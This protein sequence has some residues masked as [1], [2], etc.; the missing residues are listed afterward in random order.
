MQA[1][2]GLSPGGLN[3]FLIHARMALPK[4]FFDFDPVFL[5]V[6]IIHILSLGFLNYS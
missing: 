1:K 2:E 5:Y 4:I 3:P 6:F